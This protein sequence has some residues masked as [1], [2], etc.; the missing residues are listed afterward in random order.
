[1]KNNDYKKLLKIATAVIAITGANFE[2]EVTNVTSA[3][4]GPIIYHPVDLKGPTSQEAQ[5]VEKGEMQIALY[6]DRFAE[7]YGLDKGEVFDTFVDN[8]DV[9]TTSSNPMAEFIDLLEEGIALHVLN[10]KAT[11]QLPL[12]TRSTKRIHEVKNSN[13]GELFQKYCKRYGIDIN[14]ALAQFMQESGLKHGKFN[15]HGAYGITQIENTLFGSTVKVYNFETKEYEKIK[16]TEE[17]ARDLETNIQIGVAKLQEKMRQYDYNVY[18]GLQS[19]NYGTG[20]FNHVLKHYEDRTHKSSEDLKIQ[21]D[22]HAWEADI[23][24]VHKNPSRYTREAVFQNGKTYGDDEYISHVLGYLETP[25]LFY[26]TVD[27]N[28]LYF[29]L[30]TGMVLPLCE[31][32]ITSDMDYYISYQKYLEKKEEKRMI[33]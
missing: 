27:G 25:F 26:K 33:R 29:N 22:Y 8:Y 11:I 32:N 18:M 23:Q 28:D 15:P 4:E 14:L 3:S 7:F 12:E 16:I 24:F 9:I 19:Y 10:R 13:I 5:S 2:T 6:T 1:M 30:E 20:M 31:P 21:L 17:K